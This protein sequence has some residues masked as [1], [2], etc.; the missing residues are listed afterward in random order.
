MPHHCFEEY[1]PWRGLLAELKKI[2]M[3]RNE[4]EIDFFF[5]I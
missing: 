5:S 1:S 4:I 2:I 3:A